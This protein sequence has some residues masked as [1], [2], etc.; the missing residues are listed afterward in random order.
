MIATILIVVAMQQEANFFIKDLKLEKKGFLKKGFPPTL[1]EGKLNKKK[2]Y[3][4]VNGMSSYPNVDNVDSQAAVLSTTLGILKFHPN[5][6]ISA[7]TA[8]GSLA[9]DAHI[10]DVFVST[11]ND[12]MSRRIPGAYANYGYGLYK[13]YALPAQLI[14]RLALKSGVVCSSDSFNDS[15]TDTKVSKKLDCSVE[16]MEAAGV[17]WVSSITNTPMFSLKVITDNTATSSS[18]KQYEKDFEMTMPK[19]SYSLKAIIEGL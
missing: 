6:V 13:S 3:L 2:V 9:K 4:V 15:P 12:F 1:Y 16:E 19:L 14:K 10:G 18:Y 11:Q 7:G 5:L 8:G 17:A